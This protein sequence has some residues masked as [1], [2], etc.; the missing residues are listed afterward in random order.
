M[1]VTG[2]SGPWDLISAS[3]TGGTALA[4]DQN[5]ALLANEQR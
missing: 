2:S 4:Q 5:A 3:A 1:P